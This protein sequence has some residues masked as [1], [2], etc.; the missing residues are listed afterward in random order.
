MYIRTRN[1]R[2]VYRTRYIPQVRDR[3]ANTFIGNR[4][5]EPYLVNIILYDE[6][7]EK[8]RRGNSSYYL[9][10]ILAENEEAARSLEILLKN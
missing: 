7:E 8:Q 5:E 2:V 4:N 10:N 3:I 6:R 1:I 9:A